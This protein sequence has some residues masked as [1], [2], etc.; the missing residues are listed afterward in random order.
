[1]ASRGGAIMPGADK[2][3]GYTQ[4]MVAIL[5]IIAYLGLVILLCL[6]SVPTENK[7]PLEIVLGVLGASFGAVVAFYFSS[8]ASSR[9]KDSTIAEMAAPLP[10]PIINAD[11]KPSGT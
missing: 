3:I 5:V 7:E 10:A 9:Q 11:Q 8:T 2:G 1:M 4:H 6:R